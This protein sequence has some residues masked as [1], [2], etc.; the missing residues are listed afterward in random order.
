MR[1]WNFGASIEFALAVA[2][3]KAQS[4]ARAALRT[5]AGQAL[6]VPGPRPVDHIVA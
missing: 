1:V 4:Y 3:G 5:R 6:V 2:S